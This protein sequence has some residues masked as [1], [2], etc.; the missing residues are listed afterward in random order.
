MCVYVTMSDPVE[1][2][3]QAAEGTMYML[4]IELWS[5]G[6]AA[7]LLTAKPSLQVSLNS[8]S[9]QTLTPVWISVT[10]TSTSK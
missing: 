6:R 5:S 9:Y 8:V 2:E 4:G 1:L 10:Q 3:L 7:M